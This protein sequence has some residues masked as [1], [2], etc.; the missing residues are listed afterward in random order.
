[1]SS[2]VNNV[3]DMSQ[4]LRLPRSPSPG[5]ASLFLKEDDEVVSER[6]LVEEYL[7][8]NELEDVLNGVINELVTDRPPDPFLSLSATLVDFSKSSKIIMDVRATEVKGSAGCYLRVEVCVSAVAEGP[9]L[10]R[11]ACRF[12]DVVE[13]W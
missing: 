7:K 9:P 2:D 6:R 1:M 5:A 3:S 4:D 10:R 13:G 11:V 12:T 8:L